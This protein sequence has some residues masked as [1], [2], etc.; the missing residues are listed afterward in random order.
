MVE[1][2]IVFLLVIRI[3]VL[4]EYMHHLQVLEL[5]FNVYH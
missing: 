5:I 3:N 1:M 4:K 2:R